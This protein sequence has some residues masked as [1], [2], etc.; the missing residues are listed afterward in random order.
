[1]LKLGRCLGLVHERLHPDRLHLGNAQR[2]PDEPDRGGRGRGE[3]V[4]REVV[5]WRVGVIGV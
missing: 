3:N 5:G 4:M 2:R 1:L